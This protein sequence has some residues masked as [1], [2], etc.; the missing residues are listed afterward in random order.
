MAEPGSG[1][2]MHYQDEQED[3]DRT[4]AAKKQVNHLKKNEE[5]LRL[6]QEQRA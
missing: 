4:G 1:L 2:L 6:M 5:R 3:G